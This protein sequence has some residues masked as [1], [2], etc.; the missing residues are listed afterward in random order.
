MTTRREYIESV[1]MMALEGIETLAVATELLEE[2]SVRGAF[3]RDS[4]VGYDYRAQCWIEVTKR[5]PA[6]APAPRKR[7][8]D[9]VSPVAMPD[10]SIWNSALK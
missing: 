7:V 5:A 6:T 8:Y 4:Y 2:C 1:A 3:E 9:N 10:L